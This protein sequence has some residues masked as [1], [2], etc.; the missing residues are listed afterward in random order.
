MIHVAVIGYG[1]W[2]PN[3]V[4]NFLE[5][6]GARMAICCD[7]NAQ[8]LAH[9]E[10]KYPR[11]EMTTS[12]DDVLNNSTIDAVVIATPVATHYEFVRKALEHGKHV[13]V[14]KPL[15]A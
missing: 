6:D 14:E 3:L 5:T 8:R 1:Y 9:V 4:R 15:A 12:Y 13:L 10:S 11:V 7:M 2:G